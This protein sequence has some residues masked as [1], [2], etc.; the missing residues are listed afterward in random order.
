MTK[1]KKMSRGI[2]GRVRE[3]H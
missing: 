1:I 2:T 3:L